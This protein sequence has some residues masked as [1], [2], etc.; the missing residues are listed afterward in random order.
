MGCAGSLV[1]IWLFSRPPL[2]LV[3][4]WEWIRGARVLAVDGCMGSY[5][6]GGPGFLGLR[7]RAF[8]G[9][10]WV[11]FRLWSASDWLTLD[12]RVVNDGLFPREREGIA[13]DA[14]VSIQSLVG[15]TLEAY[16]CDPERLA[17]G[18]RGAADQARWLTLRRNGAGVLPWRGTGLP[19]T[20]PE[21]ES[22]DDVVV[23]SR[24]GR[25]WV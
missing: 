23:V 15:T 18:F 3:D 8:E 16:T 21:G 11:V 25:L 5:G 24:T 17:L 22:L 1:G 10:T 9:E 20:I 6:M 7:V 12:D 4:E 13:P 2:R 14:Q 19:K